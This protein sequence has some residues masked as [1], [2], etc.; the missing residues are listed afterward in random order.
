[1]SE[2]DRLYNESAIELRS[3]SALD[4]TFDIEK[5]QH[6]AGAK[7][8]RIRSSFLY[9][10]LITMLRIVVVIWTFAIPTFLRTKHQGY[11][12]MGHIRD[13][14]QAALDGLRGIACFIVAI[15]HFL[16]CMFNESSLIYGYTMDESLPG[17]GVRSSFWHWP[18]VRIV[19]AG[20]GMVSVFFVISGYVLSH[21][22]LTLC[23]QGRMEVALMGMSVK[24]TYQLPVLHLS[25]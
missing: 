23:Q 7:D 13:P 19:Y 20:P 16:L 8:N 18:V 14:A 6:C 3:S 25:L 15:Y 21:R 10:W 17:G 9:R 2:T 22:T 11:R 5:V 24:A 12:P 1:M 4:D